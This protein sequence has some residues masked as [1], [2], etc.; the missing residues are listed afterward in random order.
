MKIAMDLRSISRSGI[1]RYTRRLLQGLQ[2]SYPNDEFIA[3]ED[4]VSIQW[5]SFLG[6]AQSGVQR[7]WWEN[8]T[9]PRRIR[10][11]TVDVLHNPRNYGVPLYCSCPVVLTLHDVIPL[12]L[13]EDYLT[14]WGTRSLYCALVGHAVHNAQ[15]IITDS[16]YSADQIGRYF[17]GVLSKVEVILLGVDSPV[18]S[19]VTT[20][21]VYDFP[22]VLTIGGSEARKNVRRLIRAFLSMSSG[23]RGRH[24]LVV[25]GSTWRGYDLRNEFA[26][27]SQDIVFTGSL[28]DEELQALYRQATVFAFPSLCEGF[29]L[30]VLEAMALGTP[31]IC[32]NTSSLPEVAGDAALLFDPLDELSM[33]HA[34]GRVLGSQGLRSEMRLAGIGHSRKFRWEDT[35]KRVHEI[36]QESLR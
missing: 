16:L 35:V 10:A 33:A 18:E 5:D 24:R 17:P 12:S 11:E 9:L 20:K 26:N 21:P 30:P 7:L 29:G 31:T 23:I 6:R 19:A 15:R 3:L 32:S 13:S 34:L 25:V 28:S 1:G 27:S 2:H 8:V 14:K 36:Y 4:G 22:Y